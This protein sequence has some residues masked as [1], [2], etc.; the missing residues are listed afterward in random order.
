MK[1]KLLS[2]VL[3]GA[4]VASTSV[5]AFATTQ[6]IDVQ[7]NKDSEAIIPIE[8]NIESKSGEIAPGTIAVTVPTSASFKVDKNGAV[9][10]GKMNIVNK[11]EKK[12]SV[13]ASS[14]KDTTGTGSINLVK[15]NLDPTD[16]KKVSLR[17]TGGNEEIIL[18]S[19]GGGSMYKISDTS[20]AITDFELQEVNPHEQL[21]LQL[22][23]QGTAYNPSAISDGGSS[24]SNGDDPVSDKFKL[25]L[26]IKQ[27]NN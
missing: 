24:R 13:L 3:A 20:Q 12:I 16:R 7:P 23:G 18:T 27:V 14:F 6:N 1:K 26:K 4:M 15:D 8:G 17:L 11:G 10:S 22:E 9:S 25:V 2:L 5:S 21:E 19:E